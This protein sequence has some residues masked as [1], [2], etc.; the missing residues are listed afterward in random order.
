MIRAG[1]SLS[2]RLTAACDD[3]EEQM[4]AVQRMLD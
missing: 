1:R 2:E 4:A 3:D